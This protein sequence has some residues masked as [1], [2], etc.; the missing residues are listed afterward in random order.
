[1]SRGISF[2]VTACAALLLASTLAVPSPALA[3]R[4]NS[5]LTAPESVVGNWTTQDGNGVVAIE[6]CGDALCGRI[7]GIARAPREPMPTD[8]HGHPQ[9]GLI[10]ISGEHPQSDGTWLGQVTDPRSGKTYGA[11]LWLDDDGNLRLRG[12]LGIP[13]LGQTQTWHHFAGHLGAACAMA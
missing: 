7:V 13:L 5:T 4:G 3:A 8:V 2:S 6:R 1:M 11:Q 10:F 9:C 12:F